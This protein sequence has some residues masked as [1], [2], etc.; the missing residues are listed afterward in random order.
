MYPEDDS[1]SQQPP[2][3]K[4]DID[5]L[6]RQL[7]DLAREF[8]VLVNQEMRM[9]S[10]AQDSEDEKPDQTTGDVDHLSQDNINRIMGNAGTDAALS[11]IAADTRAILD[12]VKAIPAAIQQIGGV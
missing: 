6:R 9:L 7:P 3:I 1:Q 11:D 8:A 12:A 2:K 5:D 4:I 10:A